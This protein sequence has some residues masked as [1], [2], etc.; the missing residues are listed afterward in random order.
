MAPRRPRKCAG[1]QRRAEGSYGGATRTYRLEPGVGAA[2][3]AAHR[4]TQ[5]RLER[6]G[7]ARRARR[8]QCERHGRR[9]LVLRA[10]ERLRVGAAH[11]LIA[12]LARQRLAVGCPLTPVV[13]PDGVHAPLGAEAAPDR[14]HGTPGLAAGL[15]RLGAHQGQ[16]LAR[17]LE[18]RPATR[19]DGTVGTTEAGAVGGVDEDVALEVGHGA[20]RHHEPPAGREWEGLHLVRVRARV[21]GQCQ[22]Q[23]YG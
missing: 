18:R 4:R 23:G 15:L 21:S 16:R 2:P 17:R 11:E 5:H 22:G 14:D 12:R 13:G 6:L 7:T 1:I 10:R 3:H 9:A 19:R 8:E 20:R